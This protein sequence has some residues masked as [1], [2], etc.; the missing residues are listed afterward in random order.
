MTPLFAAPTAAHQ[1]PR[2]IQPAIVGHSHLRC[3]QAN[4]GP[5]FHRCE[6]G[7]E[8]A[9]MRGCVV[10]QN[11]EKWGVRCMEGLIEG[12]A[13]AYVAIVGNHSDAAAWL[14]GASAAVIYDDDLK[15]REG[16]MIE[17]V[18]ARGQRLI[19][20]QSRH[21]HRYRWVD[22]VGPRFSYH[23]RLWV[24]E[25]MQAMSG[26]PSPFRSATAQAAAEM[27]PSSRVVRF[28]RVPSNA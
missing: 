8:P 3:A 11:R 1:H 16:L 24:A 25:P 17:G 19:G 15:I 9:G 27:S 20:G 22:F 28:Q 23:F 5:L 10:I 21:H 14:N 12:R 13:K 4:V 18:Q 7:F 2:R 26:L 6:Q